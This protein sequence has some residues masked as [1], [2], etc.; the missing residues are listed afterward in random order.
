MFIRFVEE[1]LI[2]M[3]T[4]TYRIDSTRTLI[5]QSLGGLLATEILVKKPEMFDNYIIVSPSLWWDDISL[6]EIEP[7]PYSGQKSIYIAVGKEGEQMERPASDLYQ[8]LLSS[9]TGASDVYFNFL[10]GQ[11]HD[12]ALHLA[13]YDS[14]EKIFRE[15]K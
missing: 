2:P 14:F 9:D 5:G 1:E 4:S 3:I 6:L 10:E 13:V 15:R 11:D 7:Q 8:K 12:D